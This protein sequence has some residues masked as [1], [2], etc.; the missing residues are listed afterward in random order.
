MTANPISVKNKIFLIEYPFDDLTQYK[1]RPVVCLTNPVTDFNQI[2]IAFITSK[3][4]AAPEKSDVIL[5]DAD[6][7]FS[8]TGLKQKSIIRVH[9]L[10]TVPERAILAELGFIEKATHL[11][12]KKALIDL[13]SLQ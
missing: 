7:E 9:R 4:P 8:K 3:I 10:F 11:R 5:D 12:I 2:V 6:P 13:F 1:V